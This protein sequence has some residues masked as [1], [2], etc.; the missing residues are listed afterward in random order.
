MAQY[1]ITLVA[2]VVFDLTI[3]IL[4][5]IVFSMVMFVVRSNKIAIEIDDVTKDLV[6]T[7]RKTKVVYVDGSLFFGSQE[8]LTKEVEIMLS[9]QVQR[10]IFSVRGVPNIDHSSVNEF[11]EIVKMCREDKVDVLFC[12]VQ[13]AV[14]HML[15]RLDFVEYLGQNNFYTSAVIALESLS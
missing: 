1:L 6:D 12:G 7:T 8:L 11:V 14:M 9:H 15:E 4:I 3:A 5:G 2:T 10:I 13:L